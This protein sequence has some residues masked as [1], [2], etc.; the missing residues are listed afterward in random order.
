MRGN[1]V[2]QAGAVDD[3]VSRLERDRADLAAALDE[4]TARA[5]RLERANEEVATRLVKVMERLRTSDHD[6]ASAAVRPA[7]GAAS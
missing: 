3:L 4:A 2:A 1:V 6:G 5:A 7:D